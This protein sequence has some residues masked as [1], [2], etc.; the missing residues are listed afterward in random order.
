MVTLSLREIQIWK[1]VFHIPHVVRD[2]S[3]PKGSPAP[4]K[5][6]WVC[7][8]VEFKDFRVKTGGAKQIQLFGQDK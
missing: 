8:E 6:L 3:Y 2:D 4:D 1:S 5:E 7:P